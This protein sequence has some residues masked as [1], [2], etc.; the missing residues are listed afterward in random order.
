MSRSLFSAALPQTRFRRIPVLVPPFISIHRGGHFFHP[1]PMTVSGSLHLATKTWS[2]RKQGVSHV[3]LRDAC[4]LG[5][6]S[7]GFSCGTSQG[8]C[9][10]CGRLERYGLTPR[11]YMGLISHV[12]CWLSDITDP[13]TP[14][15]WWGGF[16]TKK[17][18]NYFPLL[19]FWQMWHA[20]PVDGQNCKR[21]AST[22]SKTAELEF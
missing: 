8:F 10:E 19:H 16:W 18:G 22:S 4:R 15:Y 9:A 7:G 17:L 6:T 13:N 21:F 1:D 11:F 2:D 3:T 5:D 14:R 20:V 12:S